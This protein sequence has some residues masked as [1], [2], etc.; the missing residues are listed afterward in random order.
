MYCFLLFILSDFYN[1]QY[2]NSYYTKKKKLKTALI[3]E[4]FPHQQL[5][6][7]MTGILTSNLPN[8]YGM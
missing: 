8:P 7:C 3:N 1:D 2:L 5:T 4:N 6:S